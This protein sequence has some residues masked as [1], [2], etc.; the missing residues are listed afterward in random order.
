MEIF[1]IDIRQ[2]YQSELK[3]RRESATSREDNFHNARMG[4]TP[5]PLEK[6][7]MAWLSETKRNR[8]V[9]NERNEI[10]RREME[11]RENKC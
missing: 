2:E 10:K 8:S 4:C 7:K 9:G 5:F 3:S 1:R 6:G 11:Q